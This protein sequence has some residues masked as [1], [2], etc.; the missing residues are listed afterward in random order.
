VTSSDNQEAGRAVVEALKALIR[1]WYGREGQI[2]ARGE[3][4]GIQG[5]GYMLGLGWWGVRAALVAAGTSFQTVDVSLRLDL[6]VRDL[7][8]YPEDPADA[9]WAWSYGYRSPDALGRAFRSRFGLGIGE[10]RRIGTVSRWMAM[11]E[12]DLR[13]PAAVAR[14]DEATSRIHGLKKYML[15]R[16]L[17]PDG[18]GAF[19]SLNRRSPVGYSGGRPRY[20]AIG[21]REAMWLERIKNRDA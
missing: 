8:L 10:V 16:G 12:R 21:H 17:G 1:E 5:A 14:R 7:L 11:G 15:G 20:P 13:S 19:A 2:T 4:L 9:D 3:L 18:T 6:V